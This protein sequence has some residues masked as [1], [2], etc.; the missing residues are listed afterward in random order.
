MY[1]EPF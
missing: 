1:T